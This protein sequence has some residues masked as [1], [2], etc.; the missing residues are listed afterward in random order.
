MQAKSNNGVGHKEWNVIFTKK[1]LLKIAKMR[2]NSGHFTYGEKTKFIVENDQNFTSGYV[3][4]K[5]SDSS[6]NRKCTFSIEEKDSELFHVIT[7][8][9]KDKNDNVVDSFDI[10]IPKSK[11]GYKT[12]SL[13]AYF[14]HL[15]EDTFIFATQSSTSIIK[16]YENEVKEEI[17]RV[18]IENSKIVKREYK[19]KNKTPTGTFVING[20]SNSGNSKIL[21]SKSNKI[22]A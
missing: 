11:R 3:K 15:I 6:K 4:T 2:G 13:Y 5:Y 1:D 18:N 12:N 20:K 22:V 8:I 19:R 21:K 7:Y 14:K 9:T 17:D 16:E 10:E